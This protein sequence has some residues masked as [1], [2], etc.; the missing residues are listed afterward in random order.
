MSGSDPKEKQW[1]TPIWFLGV[2]VGAILVAVMQ[3]KPITIAASDN[4]PT[5]STPVT[6]NDIGRTP[7]QQR[8][9]SESVAPSGPP[10]TQIFYGGWIV[11]R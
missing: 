7:I 8:T 4:P 1:R 2:A 9:R 10:G 11:P 5:I 6:A 3:D